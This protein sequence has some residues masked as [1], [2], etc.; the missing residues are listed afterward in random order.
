MEY[1]PEKTDDLDDIPEPF[2]RNFP[3]QS[4]QPEGEQQTISSTSITTER[5]HPQLPMRDFL[6]V[7]LV[8][9]L[10]FDD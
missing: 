5:I 7:L 6:F 8:S 10:L 4:Q 3:M 2:R 9:F 1:I